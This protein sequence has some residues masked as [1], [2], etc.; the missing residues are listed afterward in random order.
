MFN[1]RPKVLVSEVKKNSS[2]PRGFSN[3]FF[4]SRFQAERLG[5]A[6]ENSF[7]YKFEDCYK[8]VCIPA[9]FRSDPSNYSTFHQWIS[10]QGR[11]LLESSKAGQ[12]TQQPSNSRFAPQHAGIVRTK[13]AVN[14]Q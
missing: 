6:G 9:N 14:V 11:D 1:Y 8:G 3:V 13:F 10:I 5:E 2:R 4:F 12:E 7:I